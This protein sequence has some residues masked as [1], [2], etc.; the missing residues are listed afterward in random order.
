MT[1]RRPL[2]S[3][4]SE[5]KP[6]AGMWEKIIYSLR[7]VPLA[8]QSNCLEA[9][10]YSLNLHVSTTFNGHGQSLPDERT[11]TTESLCTVKNAQFQ[12]GCKIL[13]NKINLDLLCRLLEAEPICPF[14]SLRGC[15]LFPCSSRLSFYSMSRNVMCFFS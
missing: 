11:I 1:T 12:F 14:L 7:K 15:S 5:S 2:I 9:V 3:L 8:V 13:A 10:L 6:V 4:L